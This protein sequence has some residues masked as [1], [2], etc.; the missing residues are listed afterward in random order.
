MK[1]GDLVEHKYSPV[2]GVITKIYIHCD[3]NWA[4]VTW[5]DGR[6]SMEFLT[7]LERVPCK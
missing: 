4:D 7:Q 3:G 5:Y 2:L 6:E 1:I